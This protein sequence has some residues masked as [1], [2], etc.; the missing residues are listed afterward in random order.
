MQYVPVTFTI[1]FGLLCM[2][3]LLLGLLAFSVHDFPLFIAPNI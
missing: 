3:P 2:V 1:S